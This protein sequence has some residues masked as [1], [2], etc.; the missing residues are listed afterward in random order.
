MIRAHAPILAYHALL[1]AVKAAL[2]LLQVVQ[3]QL[4]L[5]ERVALRLQQRLD[6][7]AR[8]GLVSSAMIHID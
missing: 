6:L 7:D 5:N 3:L 2:L 1:A 4:L 8:A